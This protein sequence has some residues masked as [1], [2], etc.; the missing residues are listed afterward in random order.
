MKPTARLVVGVDV[1]GVHVDGHFDAGNAR[2][3]NV[4]LGLDL[5]AAVVGHCGA[6]LAKVARVAAHCGGIVILLPL[7]AAHIVENLVAGRE[8]VRAVELEERGVVVLFVEELEAA[9]VVNPCALRRVVGLEARRRRCRLRNLRGG[10]RTEERERSS[11][12][13][14]SEQPAAA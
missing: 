7:D 14:N 6:T 1:G 2:L 13:R 9:L 5:F 10:G 8:L 11:E 4:D 12:R 3:Q